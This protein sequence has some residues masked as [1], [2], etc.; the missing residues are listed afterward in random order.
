[1][2]GEFNLS[3]WALK[4]K[5]LVVYL[6]LVSAIAGLYAYGKLGREELGQGV[7]GDLF[8]R[9]AATLVRQ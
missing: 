1:M 2:S 5:S 7:G 8:K 3:E 4:H 9:A 6:M